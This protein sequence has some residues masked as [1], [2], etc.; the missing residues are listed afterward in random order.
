MI[1]QRQQNMTFPSHVSSFGN[2]SHAGMQ[3]FPFSKQNAFYLKQKL[4]FRLTL[5][6]N[7]VQAALWLV[8]VI[9]NKLQM[10]SSRSRCSAAIHTVSQSSPDGG[11]V[12]MNITQSEWGPF[13]KFPAAPFT[14][15]LL[16]WPLLVDRSRIG[17]NWRSWISILKNIYFQY[18]CGLVWLGSFTF[19]TCVSWWWQC[20]VTVTFGD[21]VEW[22][23]LITDKQSTNLQL[24][25]A[26]MPQISKMV[27]TDKKHI[28][29]SRV[30]CCLCI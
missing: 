19:K 7:I 24:C 9:F 14:Y 21:V 26:V 2:D 18:F 3:C 17:G 15:L 22:Q 5:P 16:V 13:Y 11:L 1:G 27:Q 28:F 25:D 8:S 10:A 6:P 12:N 20:G 30:I 23:I 4:Y 29:A